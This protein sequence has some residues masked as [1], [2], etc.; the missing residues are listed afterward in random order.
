MVLLAMTM[1]SMQVANFCGAF[2][3]SG[4][5]PP[6][7]PRGIWGKPKAQVPGEGNG[8]QDISRM[9]ISDV[10]RW[11]EDLGLKKYAAKF[12]EESID[13]RMLRNLTDD[14]LQTI[15]VDSPMHRKKILLHRDGPEQ[16][17]P[18]VW[19]PDLSG[20]GDA[21]LEPQR[22][23]PSLLQNGNR[24]FEP[25]VEALLKTLDNVLY[26]VLMEESLLDALAHS[27]FLVCHKTAHAPD[28]SKTCIR[29]EAH[30]DLEQLMQQ[31]L[32]CAEKLVAIPEAAKQLVICLDTYRKLSDGK[33]SDREKEKSKAQLEECFQTWTEKMTEQKARSLSISA[34]MDRAQARLRSQGSGGAALASN[35]DVYGSLVQEREEAAM[36]CRRI[37]NLADPD[38]QLALLA[39][40]KDGLQDEIHSVP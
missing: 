7:V 12:R 24:P 33:L 16:E 13:G 20:S 2:P 26:E 27:N 10:S 29:E 17:A 28:G 36:Q 6:R 34:L 8:R 39:R 38:V 1:R 14:D 30:A 15:G 23:V 11:L 19:A 5:A 18:D 25:A 40:Q 9:D 35:W 32:Q 3:P 31:K 37:S 4:S 21:L 22:V